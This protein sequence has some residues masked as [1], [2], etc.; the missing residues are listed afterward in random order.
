[1]TLEIKEYIEA[2]QFNSKDMG[3]YI[4]GRD[5]PTPGEK[6]ITE[7]LDYANGV[8]DFSNITGER[9]YNQRTHTFTL[10]QGNLNYET[11]K[12]LEKQAK[13]Q[14]MNG[15]DVKLY[16][17]HDKGVYWLG[18]CASVKVTDDQS[19][20]SLTLS[21]EFSLYP[22]AIKDLTDSRYPPDEWNNFNFNNDFLQPFTFE[23]QK[24][25]QI[26]LMNLGETQISPQVI[27]SGEIVIYDS[28]GNNYSFNSK[29]PTDY[30]FYLKRG[31]NDLTITCAETATV[32][33]V[34]K[35]EVMI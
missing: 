19:K 23:V 4:T 7:N 15:Y 2:G 13:S 26:H 17:S 3:F 18:K 30:L 12:G 28:D 34:I 27:T 1:M 33:F 16:D 20:R 8:L 24:N 22:Y 29:K 10:W 32:R 35:T 14:L 11:R 5:A 9:F 21:V 25:K 6:L 31:M